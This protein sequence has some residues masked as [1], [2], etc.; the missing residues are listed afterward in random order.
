MPRTNV[1]LRY[2]EARADVVRKASLFRTVRVET[3][4][5]D[6]PEKCCE[7]EERIRGFV[8]QASR[9]GG[10][11]LVIPFRVQGFGPYAKVLEGR[12][13]VSDGRG[14]GSRS[15]RDDLDCDP[16]RQLQDA[17]FRAAN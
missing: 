15:W 17:D 2:L 7:A 10:R 16:D 4:R 11:A 3:L 9:N 8:A 13:Y 14:P 5:E 6:W 1:W 12:S